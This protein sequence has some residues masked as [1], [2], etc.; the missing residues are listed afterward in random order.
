MNTAIWFRNDLRVQDNPA[1]T[2]ACKSSENT[3]AF[4]IYTPDQHRLHGV[5]EAKLHFILQNVVSLSKELQALGIDLI[6]VKTSPYEDSIKMLKGLCK[7]HN[8]REL[9]ANEE[10]ELNEVNRDK[11]AI[12]LLHQEQVDL[13]LHND[14]TLL[15]P[16]SVLTNKG[17][18]Y[19]VFTPF[20]RSW[21]K[22]IQ[23]E[24]LQPLPIPKKREA[25]GRCATSG[26]TIMSW[27][28]PQSQNLYW[29][30]G[31]EEAYRRLH[32]FIKNHVHSYNVLRDIPSTEATS[33][34]SPYLTVGAISARSC[35]HLALM[36]NQYQWSEGSIGVTTWI[37]ELIWREFYKH[38]TA[39]TPSI[40]KGE[41]MQP[42]TRHIPWLQDPH[43]LQT[44]V[45]GMTGFPMVDAGMRQ[46]KELGW[47]HNRLRM[48]TAMFLS[49]HLFVNWRL[50]E[51]YFMN[52]LMD[53]DF[54]ANNGGWQWSS[55]T[56]ADAAPY[57]R[58]FNPER[59]S[60][61]FDK[62]GEFIRYWVPEL[63]E[64]SNRNIHN[65]TPEQRKIAG[66]PLPIVNHA[67]AT[68]KTKLAFQ[69]VNSLEAI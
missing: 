40:C 29:K 61:R 47:M 35:I 51:Q 5:G 68:E 67:E 24:P 69:T 62:E 14:Q 30:P 50:G 26:K 11:K 59:Q 2:A 17:E 56:G 45:D 48:I 3:I 20:K 57:F 18:T 63:R 13:L 27:A 54:S 53:A 23:A 21:L 64:I 31:S 8:V 39:L 6:A 4:Y 22:Q 28:S 43:L 12:T 41:P 9:H 66:Y 1:L 42:K 7:K 10:P 25:S 44:W 16:G 19:R 46:L 36:E 32:H 60:L 37:N 15:S 55:S 52:S 33:Q 65:P 38:L 58:I 34:L 49:K